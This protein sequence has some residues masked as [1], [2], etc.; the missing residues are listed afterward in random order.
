MAFQRL[1]RGR[2]RHICRAAGIQHAHPVLNPSKNLGPAAPSRKAK[3]LKSHVA[4]GRCTQGSLSAEEQ[5]WCPRTAGSGGGWGRGLSRTGDLTCSARSS[6]RTPRSYH[7]SPIEP[8]TCFD[9]SFKGEL[10]NNGGFSSV[11]DSK[12]NWG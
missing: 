1:S 8:L 4:N 7:R 5:L 6:W 9:F 3:P 12:K 10:A 11:A 2:L